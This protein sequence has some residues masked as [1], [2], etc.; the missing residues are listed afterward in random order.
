M[1]QIDLSEVK[2]I[3]ISYLEEK[4]GKPILGYTMKL[5]KTRKNPRLFTIRYYNYND[6]DYTCKRC[7]L[8]ISSDDD[9]QTETCSCNMDYLTFKF[10]DDK[11]IVEYLSFLIKTKRN[12]TIRVD[13]LLVYYH[14]DNTNDADIVTF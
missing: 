11:S 1:K 8:P 5:L 7:G 6:P 12:V 13:E 3:I 4:D 9:E 14:F 10:K 2:D